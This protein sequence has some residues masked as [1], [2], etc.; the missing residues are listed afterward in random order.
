M[1]HSILKKECAWCK[2]PL[3]EIQG[4]G[5]QGVTSGI[6]PECVRIETSYWLIERLSLI[7]TGISILNLVT[8][9]PNSK[10]GE[11]KR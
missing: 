9:K 2:M 11:L 5:V 1:K 10:N 6:C 7:N 4:Y 3:G 8:G